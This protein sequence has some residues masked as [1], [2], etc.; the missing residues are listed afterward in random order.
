MRLGICLLL[1]ALV[2]SCTAQKQEETLTIQIRTTKSTNRGTP[3]YMIVKEATM[4]EYLLDDYHEIATQSF[5]KESEEKHL[6]KKVI[7]PGKTNKIVIDVPKKEGSM[8]LYF[9]FSNPGE[10]WKYMIDQPQS[11]RV[12][13][14]LGEDQYEAINVYDG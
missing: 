11:K 7:I 10:C 5:W 12:K 6:V 4:A 1:F 8:G 2:T 14:L 9:I 13:V 3:L